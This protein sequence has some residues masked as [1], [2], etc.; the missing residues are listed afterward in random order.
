[1]DQNTK[2]KLSSM[3]KESLVATLISVLPNGC[4][5][6]LLLP[7]QI[8]TERNEKF[9]GLEIHAIDAMARAIILQTVG[10]VDVTG[11]SNAQILPRL[12]KSEELLTYICD[13]WVSLGL[14]SAVAE[15][16]STLGMMAKAAHLQEEGLV[17]ARTINAKDAIVEY[18]INLGMLSER[19]SQYADAIKYHEEALAMAHD[20][21]L[22][23]LET[24]AI[25]ALGTVNRRMG[26]NA[27]AIRLLEQA[28]AMRQQVGA[29]WDLGVGWSSRECRAKGPSGQP[30]GPG[31]DEGTLTGEILGNLGNAH[32]SL[33]NYAKAIEYQTAGREVMRVCGYRRGEGLNLGNLGNSYTQ[34]EDHETAMLCFTEALAIA[35]EVGDRRGE[36]N[37]LGN[38]ALGHLTLKDCKA[39]IECA[40]A[41]IAIAQ[42]IGDK[43]GESKRLFVLGRAYNELHDFAMSVRHMTSGISI[44]REIGHTEQ[45]SEGLFECAEMHRMKGDLQAARDQ[46]QE[47]ISLYAR[48]RSGLADEQRVR[49][50]EMYTHAYRG[51]VDSLVGLGHQKE[52][53]LVAE[54][55]RSRAL[56]D[57]LGAN[58]TN[59]EIAPLNWTAIEN[60]ASEIKGCLISYFEGTEQLYIWV[61]IPN[62]DGPPRLEFH[63][64][65]LPPDLSVLVSGLGRGMRGM[66]G[67]RG[68]AVSCDMV[69]ALEAAAG[70]LADGAA[71]LDQEIDIKRCFASALVVESLLEKQMLIGGLVRAAHADLQRLEPLI[72]IEIEAQ[73]AVQSMLRGLTEA[74]TQENNFRLYESLV[75]PIAHLLPGI[76]SGHCRL[77]FV[78]HDRICSVPFGALM[79]RAEEGLPLLATYEVQVCNALQVLRLTLDNVNAAQ[80]AET[81]ADAVVVGYPNKDLPELMLPGAPDPVLAPR[82]PY[83]DIEAREVAKHLQTSALLGP[84]ATKAAVLDRLPTAPVTHIATHG[85]FDQNTGKSVLLLHDHARFAS[86]GGGLLGEA[87]LD[88][89]SLKLVAQL[90]VIPACHSGRGKQ[91][92]GE[93][94]VGIG[95]ALLACGVPTVVL[96]LWALPDQK[97]CNIMQRFYSLLTKAGGKEI[98]EINA[99]GVLR[100]AIMQEFP[101][102]QLRQRWSDWGGLQVLGAGTVRLP[103]RADLQPIG[104]ESTRALSTLTVDEVARLMEHLKFPSIVSKMQEDEISGADLVHCDDEYLKNECKLAA[105]KCIRFKADLSRLQRDGVDGAIFLAEGSRAIST[106]GFAEWRADRVKRI[107]RHADCLEKKADRFLSIAEGDEKRAMQLLGGRTDQWTEPE[108]EKPEEPQME[109]ATGPTD[110]KDSHMLSTDKLFQQMKSTHVIFSFGSA[111]GGLDLAK[112]LRLDLLRSKTSDPSARSCAGCSTTLPVDPTVYIDAV[113]LVEGVPGY[114]LVNG[115]PRNKH[116]A[117]YYFMGVLVAKTVVLVLDQVWAKSVWC[118]AE[119]ELFRDNCQ[120]AFEAAHRRHYPGSKFK[121]IVVYDSTEFDGATA[122]AAIEAQFGAIQPGTG[123]PSIFAAQF[124]SE[125]QFGI[126]GDGCSKD[127]GS[128]GS[129]GSHSTCAQCDKERKRFADEAMQHESFQTGQA[130]ESKRDYCELYDLH[131]RA[132]ADLLQNWPRRATSTNEPSSEPASFSELED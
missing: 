74:N 5:Q 42:E 61:V 88:P 20:A 49:I 73:P 120:H 75:A 32:F 117:E 110:K 108:A 109:P 90:A 8:S 29:G 72:K 18:L 96:S 126:V 55:S 94:L 11:S 81:L 68:E 63:S 99:A 123:Q 106:E 86:G 3:D 47:A 119:S 7:K 107:M 91:W 4:Y 50:F 128:H 70:A 122:A 124:D 80:I 118:K 54:G 98:I 12:I 83:A 127:D 6:I 33:H 111:N 87:E 78:P 31:N 89:V 46:Y 37:R 53:L 132:E 103:S 40:T 114:N 76:G 56:V 57:L 15:H 92:S 9:S 2:D 58:R 112:K 13:H 105:P 65:A 101:A 26:N 113:N 25:T 51:L 60:M 100:T 48:L 116:W 43:Q 71:D 16:Y 129:H 10:D 41:S 36:G 52:A 24:K 34:L 104:L 62:E 85:F 14:R 115:T 82:L 102:N 30:V 27:E 131:W 59:Q 95:R 39:A 77:I 21:G 79:P 17:I 35:R 69:V 66:R 45:E 23:R 67:L 28:M 125:S 97:A 1:M 22:C 64:Q 38:I 121:L 44:A 19:S 130:E 84:E 93:G